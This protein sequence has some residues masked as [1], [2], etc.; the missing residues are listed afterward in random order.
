MYN[1]DVMFKCKKERKESVFIAI[2]KAK[3][4]LLV[5]ALSTNNSDTLL[6]FWTP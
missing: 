2:N 3:N 6:C 1:K 5:R 4:S